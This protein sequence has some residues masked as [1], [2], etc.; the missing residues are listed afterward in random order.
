MSACV[1]LATAIEQGA[2]AYLNRQYRTIGIVGG[3]L[4]V[5]IFATLGWETAIGF[6]IGAILSGLA[7]FIG[8]NVSVKA[9]SRTAEAAKGGISPALDVAFRGGAITGMLVVGLGLLGVAGYFCISYC[10]RRC[11]VRCYTRPSRAG[12]W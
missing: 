8:M 9:N 12:F 6:A 11:Y 4:L 5:I 2:S 7:G 3:V 10:Y 1:R